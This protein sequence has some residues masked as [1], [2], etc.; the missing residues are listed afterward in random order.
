RAPGAGELEA[1]LSGL[2][3]RVSVVACDV[4][5]RGELEG[6]LAGIP[7]E[8]PL[9][10]VVHAAGVLDDGVLDGLTPRRFGA[11]FRAK[12]APALLLDELT[13][14]RDLSAFVLFSSVAGA[15]GNPGQANYAAAN[16]VLDALAVR[17]RARGLVA[18]S[19]AWGAWAGGGMAAGVQ[20]GSRLAD[21]SGLEPG[22]AVELLGE[23]VAE[24][25]AT[26]IVADLRRKDVLEALF[27]LRPSPT[28][29]TLP[30]AA[31]AQQ[32]AQL[33]RRGSESAASTL[34]AQLHAAPEDE[35]G[36]LLI[37]L[38]QT[39]AAGVLGHTQPDT[40]SPDRA[41]QDL[42]FDS[43]TS[44]ELR[45]R[46][47]LITGLTLPAGLL[48]DY[49]RPRVLA[50]HLEA[51]LLG[52]HTET[53]G[54]VLTAA[55]ADTAD[56]PVVIVGMACRFPGGVSSPEQLWDLVASG[57][58][59]IAAF[60]SDRGWEL[61]GQG[62]FLYDAADFDPE[63]FGISP[64]EALA[65]DP[66]QRLLLEVSWEAIERA[67]ID[68]VGLR[69]SQTGV[70]VGSNSVD[71]VHLIARA[72]NMEGRGVM[73][74]ASV[75][76]G[77]L[78][79]V[80]GLE[81]PAVTVD[82]ACSSSLVSLHLAAQALRS[83]ECSLA[84]AGGVTVMT[85]SSSFVGFQHHGGL[86][87]DGRCKAFADTADGTGWSEGVGVLV[88]ERMSDALRNG[89]PIL[90]VV[91]GSA[92]NQDGASNG[93]TAPN[94]PSQQRVIRQ[95]LAGAGLRPTDVDAVEAHGTGTTLGDPIEA[96]ALLAAY[97]QD[98]ER[99]L[100]LGSVKSNIGHTQAA[101]GAAGLIK[102]V[103][104]IQHGVLPRTLH[105]DAPSSHVD[106]SA[107]AIELLREN[108]AWPRTD[109]PRRA[110]VSSFGISGTNGHV[111][112][113]QA[114]PPEPEPAAEPAVVPVDVVPWPLSATTGEA[115][116]AQVNRLRSFVDAPSD[117]APLDIGFSLATGRSAF[118][119]RAV[120]LAS[121]DSV[122]EVARGTVAPGPLAVLFTGQGAQRLGMGR[123]LY[124]RFP[125]FAEALDAATAELGG[126]LRETLWGDDPDVLNRTG[127]AQPALFALE[128]ALFR[129]VESLGVTP[130][131][132][133]GHS[134]GEIAAAHVAG[135]LSLADA[136][137]LVGARARLM[138][139]LPS[140]GAMVAV[141]A[142]E[143]EIAP[144][145]AEASG[146]VSVAAV[147]G[148]SS[149]VISGEEAAVLE[150]TARFEAEGRRTKRLAVSHAFHSPLMDP[151]L[152]EFRSVV[153]GLEFGAPSIPVVSNLTGA[154]AV[155][156]EICSP[157]YWVRH[158]RETVRFA[159][160]IQTLSTEGVRA[161]L[162]LGPGGVLSALVAEQVPDEAVV[163][164]VLRKDRPEETAAVTA[165]AQLHV[166]GVPLD[167]RAFFA[168]TGARRTDLP[169]YAFQRRRFWPVGS[170]DVGDVGAAGL[171]SAEHPLLGAAVSLADSDG[172]V[173]AGRLSLASHPWLSDHVVMGHVLLPGTAFVELAI[174]AGDEV[175][176]ER[177]EELILSA[178]LVLPEEGAV[179]VQMFVGAADDSGRRSV[180]I[181]A[182]GESSE[183]LPW[184]QHATGLLAA[185][186]PPQ[187]SQPDI[188]FDA[189]IWPP[190]GAVSVDLSDCYERLGQLGFDYGPGFQGL[191]AVWK[192]GSDVF[193]EVELP[194]EV[195][196]GGFGVHP[197]LL[198]AVLHA[199]GSAELHAVGSEGG[200]RSEQ[201]LGLPFSWEGVT[202]HAFEATAVRARLTPAGQGAMSLV[203][204]D[205]AGDLVASIESFVTRPLAPDQ[206][207]D[208]ARS[209]RDSLFRVEWA[210]VLEPVE[211]APSMVAVVGSDEGLVNALRE[212][213]SEVQLCADLA[214]LA[215][216][217]GLAPEVVLIG[218]DVVA[219]V[220]VGGVVGGVR[221]GV[222]SV[223][224]LVQAWLAEERFADSRLVVVSRGAVVGRDLEGLAVA[225]VWGLLRS[226]QAEH[227][228]RIALLDLGGDGVSS[229]VL[230]RAL[231][232]AEPEVAVREGHIVIPRLARVGVTGSAAP[233]WS[234]SG[235]VLITG[236]TGGLGA[237]VARHLA[238]EHG[239]RDLLLLSRRGLEAP[240]AAE[241]VGELSGLGARVEVVACDV[242]DREA[243]AGVLDGR[244]VSGV[245]HAAGVLDDGVIGGLSA[246]RV[247]AVLRPKVDAAWHLHELVGE[248][249]AFVVFS[250]AAGVLGSAG[251]GGYAAANAFLN[252]LVEYRRGLGLPGVSLAWGA[253][254][255]P[256]GM[257]GELTDLDRERMIRSGFPP[258]SV[259]QG[260]A[261]FDAAVGSEEAVVVPMRLDFTV[262]RGR[263]EVLPLLRGLIRTRRSAGGAGAAS[264][265]LT[266]RLSELDEA[267]RRALLLEVVRG[268]VAKV[269]G[270]DSPAVV[271]PARAFRDLG[272][273]SLMAVE[274]RN[275]LSAVT[276]LRLPATLVFDY[277]TVQVLADHLL[278]ELFAEAVR[279]VDR[280]VGVLPSVADDPVVIVGMGCRYPGEVSSP[281]ELWELVAGEVDAVSE[282]PTDRG[283]DLE[284]LYH[285]DPG[286]LG[287][288]STRAG[289]FLRG[290]GEFD[291]DFFGMSPGAA[292]ATDA[293]QRLLLEVAWEAVERAGVDPVSLRGSRT[294]VFA[295]V[296]YNDYASL[297]SAAEFEGFRGN[298][299]A[300]S[301]ASG[302]VSY[303]LGLEG[304][305]MTVDTACSSSL[306]ALHLAVQALRGGECS[307]ALAG[308]VTVMSTPTT[309]V[310]FS[311]QRGLAPDGRC[312]AFGEGADGVGWAEGV[313]VLVL[314]RMSDAV[315]NG[316]RVLAVVRGSAVNQD[317]ASNGLT[318]P[319]G[320]SQQRVIRQALASA[321]L[322]AADVD[323]VEAHGTGT[324]LGD[325][326]EAQALL[327]TYGQG[328][329]AERPLL[330][331]SVKSNLG[332]TQ[333]AAGVAGVIKTVMAMHHGVLPRTLHADVP[334]SHVDWTVGDVA[335]LTESTAWPESDRPRRAGVSSFGVS[336]TNA[337]VILEQ[338][339]GV[340]QPADV[341]AAAPRQVLGKVPWM[342]SAR[343]GTALEQQ[344][345]RVRSFVD[346]QALSPLDVGFSL[347][348]SRSLF[349][350]RAVLLADEDGVTEVSRG[351][352]VE[353]GLAV[354][355]SGQGAQRLGMG[356]ELYG[357][358]PVF[359]E[360]L[361]AVLTHLDGSVRE[362][363]W[364]EDAEA[365]EL[366]RTAY[367]QQALFAV[368]VALFRLVESWGVR[369]DYVAGHSIGEVAAAHVAGVLSLADACALVAAR[370]RLMEAL[371]AG[372][373]MVAVQVG[374]DEVLSVLP[375]GVAVAAVNGPSSLV[376]SGELDAMLET[377]A[378]FEDRTPRR[379][380]V[381]H[382]FHSPL[383]DPML[384][385]FR[386]LVEGL[387]FGAPSI[388]VVSN[389]SGAVA[390]SEEICSPEYWVRHVRETVR[391]ADGIQTLT[392]EGVRAFLELGPD[393]VLS[394]LIGEQVPDAAVAVPILR[395]DRSE[396]TAAVSALAR[397][398]VS[399][400]A[401]DWSAFFAGTGARRVDLPT[402]AFQ[403]EHYWPSRSPLLADL[404]GVGL[405]PA[406]HPLVGAVVTVAGSEE[407]VMSGT[408]S[409]AALPWLA[410]HRVGGRV[411][412]PGTG[413]LELAIRAADQ[414][415]CDRVDELTIAAPLVLPEQGAIQIQL[416]IA[417]SDEH[418]HRGVRFYS[419][420]AGTTTGDWNL[421]ATGVLTSGALT[422]EFDTTAWPPPGAVPVD[423]DGVY[424][425][426][427]RA[428]L[429]YGPA[430]RG[431]RA[432]WR[433]GDEAFV[434]TALLDQAPEAGSFGVH[435]ALLD[436]VLHASVF[437]GEESTE[438]MLPFS[439]N[440]VSL[441]ASGAAVLR[442]RVVR[443]GPDTVAVAATD[444]DGTPVV[445]VDSLTL[446][447]SSGELAA[448]AAVDPNDSLHRVEWVSP[449]TEPM[450][451]TG[452]RWAVIGDDQHDLG[453]AMALVGETI[454][455]Y[456]ETLAGAI[457]ESGDNGPVPNGFV[458]SVSGGPAPDAAHEATHRAL[459][460][461][462]EWLAE[463]KF[464]R[465]R[466]IFVTRGAMAADGEEVRD[467]AAAAVWGL[468][469]S[470]QSENPGRFL[471]VDID[472]AHI[473]AGVLPSLL[474]SDEEQW[475]LR[476]RSA[477]VPRL[478][479]VPER[480]PAG[481]AWNPDGT[482]LITG[483]TGGLGGELARHLVAGHGVRHLVLTSRRGP[484]AP[485]AAELCDELTAAG[486]QVSVT[487]CD[488][489]D[490][491]ALADLLAG[492]PAE[493]P[494]TAVVH[495]AGVLDD[496]VIGAQTPERV[497]A[498]L[499]PKADAAWHLHQA[500]R[501]LDL[502]AFVL[503]SSV[504]GVTG[505]QGQASYAAAS[506][507]L[508]ALAEY[509]RGQGLPATSLAWGLWARRTGMT[510]DLT[511]IDIQRMNR[512][513]TPPL[514]LELG[515]AL[516]DASL[517]RE[518]AL[519]VPLRVDRTRA[520]ERVPSM[521]R[522]LIA[523]ARPT[524]AATNRSFA[525]LRDRLRG[526]E[527]GEQQ[528]ML[529]DLVVEIS[530]VLIGQR[531]PGAV[532]PRRD[533][534]TLG[535]DS[536]IAIELRNQLGE[537]LGL[538]VPTSAVFDNRTPLR[539]A[540]W[541]QERI[542]AQG[543]PVAVAGPGA[544]T[545]TAENT[546]D[547]LAEMFFDTVRAGKQLEAMR[548]LVAVANTRPFCEVSAE[549]AELPE[550]VTL[551]AGPGKP[552]LICISAPGAN[553][554]VHQYARVAS[555]FRGNRHVS[556]LPLL[557]FAEG[558]SLPATSEAA[559]RLI[560]ESALLASDGEPFV[561][562]GYSLGGT[563]A[564]RAAGVMEETWGIRPDGLIMLDTL[565]L[566]YQDG[567][568]VDW[569]LFHRNYL[570]SLDTPSVKLSSARLSAMA[571]WFLQMTR[572]RAEQYTTSVPS[573][574]IRCTESMAGVERGDAPPPVPA[575]TTSMIEATHQTLI[576]DASAETARLMDEW[577][578]TLES[579]GS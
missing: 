313:G 438:R 289:G 503:Y 542:A 559:V 413:F 420:P 162:E 79:Y 20:G 434:E 578:T 264:A 87:P 554:G 355:F 550:P 31:E 365:E 192:H 519:L 176:C 381:S 348:T 224:A 161:F 371:P 391:F 71:Y 114:P 433:R 136:C 117:R 195:P 122:V 187:G 518:E 25:E 557:G 241:L 155:A 353:G 216:A 397:L 318:A 390:G 177:I 294:G 115:L 424:E 299:S 351:V 124:D 166:S 454:A 516:F 528:E 281:E 350:H 95:A 82:T 184:T 126:A 539:L 85:T 92:V 13:R 444:V 533:F 269:L 57:G 41:F 494:L 436:A 24:P 357:R 145:V 295:G 101:A 202:L 459:A 10:G 406:G 303:V 189:T 180:T 128:V 574:L 398:H 8:F 279:V 154:V 132:V 65:M 306:V 421:H 431:L 465:S 291:A 292:L 440:G 534:L 125:V 201:G 106:W 482:V 102:T 570:A 200:S 171:V 386:R 17:R 84:L 538:R 481:R 405:E 285:P 401:V 40:I 473:S 323:V 22:L 468:V 552:R 169:T 231:A 399:G 430:F 488:I 127:T 261:W 149:V 165:L 78:S 97:G 55:P 259:E 175:G 326:I 260:V 178:P 173:F 91:R 544:L 73:L 367:A 573:L 76:S 258:V 480:E 148:P 415:G 257:T 112:L 435:P 344:V 227:P 408:L 302:R 396:E 461:I 243:L 564:Y 379:L 56:D 248:V 471:L 404:S 514:T 143:N 170:V 68:L 416:R 375:D 29:S 308:G 536:L 174:R 526:L 205:S 242:A 86:A 190:A 80:F 553:G 222:F 211:V 11:V 462:Q 324:R 356:R 296:M 342:V 83:G 255:L 402:Y 74:A 487:A 43:L 212:M 316:H 347:A 339:L 272:F 475:M 123:E 147:N 278:E 300:L 129:L 48:F 42:G 530:A 250:S 268:Q 448:P 44:M 449:S 372:G 89:H 314:E 484:E 6:V 497:D 325:P 52:L 35:R 54:P 238:A 188:P 282:F 297:L 327:A 388:A 315:R 66:Q 38:I 455:A 340:E 360:A 141:Q 220:A 575:D 46:L 341:A 70:F 237:V 199:V 496:G 517:T 265:G 414:V 12:V 30:A 228:D 506:T 562:V 28:L 509:R 346:E 548:L 476:Q 330:L 135:V 235:S 409:T 130:K 377:A 45:S 403:H 343:T 61:E 501:E 561:L 492:I 249:S 214:A 543:G 565:S 280:P 568:G 499:R 394:A 537:A 362:V 311:R 504:S 331:G 206:L 549:V 474:T 576:A 181:Y 239:V 138:E 363:M 266:Q 137:V 333:A 193:A 273:D 521:L 53:A 90:A 153:E 225:S 566:E 437:A 151:M 98:R 376:L 144:L 571:H 349:E 569:D 567:E 33:V 368:E 439:W 232:L 418:G 23:L 107:G 317:G 417:E 183:E 185:S 245:V 352:P 133:A 210:P 451:V 515:L 63:F 221:A 423:L 247:G 94:G 207:D 157:E 1:E 551:A 380:R 290:A 160:G 72:R 310:E 389:L 322:S 446:R 495:T 263:G 298:A 370:A 236:G 512:S 204:A 219:E 387:E 425:G 354:V 191:R 109:R 563:F 163:V 203:L 456:A 69:G 483:G 88:V 523:G 116:E 286:H 359:A 336:G 113:E 49:P 463:E 485:G 59:A 288:S 18:T 466:L 2:G 96:H 419:R 472:D 469:R 369:P 477:R 364:G 111:I 213:G 270:H 103:M 312:K 229:A 373:A 246:E 531:D 508:D 525:T 540:E 32:S 108:T 374:E 215:E 479:K 262:I 19:V 358:F 486:A 233:V 168:G 560:A 547:S 412:F 39:H 283:W 293:Q 208:S 118:E 287:T 319:N 511:E 332:H 139:A 110:G 150:V 142:G 276:G 37:D 411:F 366:N 491:A 524:A 410:E 556:A 328:R 5:N 60:P 447:A 182:R 3:V 520:L 198:D 329:D 15:V 217:D 426:Y 240:D 382:A 307:L 510:G 194:E 321:G 159:E 100:L 393:G 450:P 407:L 505:S 164:P 119:H 256:T 27:S 493:H 4:A 498:V 93:L 579:E 140:G 532:D 218:V 452:A 16:A 489:A 467:L 335:L 75:M 7:E 384:D 445:S 432:V 378:R 441:H 338:P 427:A 274:L 464:A 457:G 541:L 305:A 81:G 120:L 320:P 172:V 67:G 577:L 545:A 500:T 152:D 453:Q 460:L 385:E 146:R 392:A 458:V 400:V 284:R 252:A 104:A 62:G 337:H 223:L 99:P 254:D 422:A 50:E 271:D 77:R 361:D 186:N 209:D 21:V 34:R 244:V 230:T 555:R 251:Q 51:E 442:A 428:G 443:S 134:V 47:A 478:A 490:A 345:H 121:G 267:G 226:A 522:N 58:D 277:P 64:R 26:T 535:F 558:E 513:G 196:A 197:A 529:V 253:W 14:D 131:F 383:M 546:Q 429:E 572:G 470:A 304:P 234:G 156:E 527:P 105:V 301:V 36:A 275:A 507:Y 309:F 9:T 395:K 502:D 158:V 167:W 334:S 179:Q